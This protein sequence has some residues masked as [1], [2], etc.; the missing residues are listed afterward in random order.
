M[1]W[2]YIGR[3]APL[4]AR[5]AGVTLQLGL[6]A[7]A[8]SI[9]M[10]LAAALILRYRVPALYGAV[11]GYIG[12][13]RNTPLLAQLFFLYFGLPQIG[14][15]LSGFACAVIGLV[16]LGSSYMAESFQSGFDSVS[17][18]QRESAASLGLSAFQSLRFVELPSAVSVAVPSI[19]ANAIFL[20][21]ETS[22]CGAIAIPD[23]VHTAN[24]QIGMYYKTYEALLLLTFAYVALILPLSFFFSLLERRIRH[25]EFGI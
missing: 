1:N 25:A 23:L 22:I 20:L 16:F 13:S 6:L 4:F 2:G 19:A 3:V 15:T 9:I 18:I 10:G 21:K 11:R 24:D 8:L 5:A 7:I 17:V 14:V 12:L